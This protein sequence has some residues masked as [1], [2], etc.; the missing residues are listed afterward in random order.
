MFL[1][2]NCHH[3]FKGQEYLAMEEFI[4]RHK[5]DGVMLLKATYK[6]QVTQMAKTRERSTPP[7]LPFEKEK[8]FGKK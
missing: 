4:H 5:D 7:A 2:R 8:I 1:S 3:I 6:I